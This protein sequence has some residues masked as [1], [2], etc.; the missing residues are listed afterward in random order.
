MPH[1]LI[2]LA[3]PAEDFTLARYVAPLRAL[4]AVGGLRPP[5]AC[6]RAHSTYGPWSTTWRSRGSTRTSGPS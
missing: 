4:A 2:D 3:D 1:H 6:R 5:G